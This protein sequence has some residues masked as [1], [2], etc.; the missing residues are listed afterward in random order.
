MGSQARRENDE[1]VAIKKQ[2]DMDNATQR[3]LLTLNQAKIGSLERDIEEMEFELATHRRNKDSPSSSIASGQLSHNSPR[4]M[5]GSAHN[6]NRTPN[7]SPRH[8]PPGSPGSVRSNRYAALDR[9][10]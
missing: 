2:L 9:R 8:S 4:D 5:W 6:V 7:R 10:I 1:Y 3:Q